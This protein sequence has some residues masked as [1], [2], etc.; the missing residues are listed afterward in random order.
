ML[1]P[2]DR[3]RTHAASKTGMKREMEDGRLP[4]RDLWATS[5]SEATTGL[6]WSHWCVA[7]R[8]C[9]INWVTTA[10]PHHKTHDASPS[11][12]LR[13]ARVSVLPAL[14]LLPVPQLFCR[15]DSAEYTLLESVFVVAEI[16]L[17]EWPRI[18]VSHGTR[19]RSPAAEMSLDAS[20][21]GRSLGRANSLADAVAQPVVRLAA[22]PPPWRPAR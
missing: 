18:F 3:D 13:S 6:A 12:W 17:N 10:H 9:S 21:A 16:A 5:F 20:L 11:G 8:R 22:A 1:T 15:G 14:S 2:K 7:G 19:V 4:H